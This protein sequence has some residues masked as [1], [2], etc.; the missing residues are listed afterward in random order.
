MKHLSVTCPAHVRYSQHYIVNYA[1]KGALFHSPTYRERY[2]EFLKI[3][4]PRLPLTSDVELFREL[5]S[6]GDRLVGLHL[7]EKFGKITARYPVGGN[8]VV[9]KIEYTYAAEEPEKGRV[10]INKAQYFEGVPPGVWEFY[11]GGYQVCQ[12]W[13]KDRKGRILEFSD[14]QHYQCIVAALS[15]TITLMARIDEVIEEH[16]G[17]PLGSGEVYSIINSST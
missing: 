6:L 7:V 16:G 2:A 1:V 12:K 14:I 8:H 3:D 13:L 11:V 9:E 15:E 5:C 17:W 10:W 4:F